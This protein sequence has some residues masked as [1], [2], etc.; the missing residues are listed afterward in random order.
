[1]TWTMLGTGRRDVANWPALVAALPTMT[2]AWADL[3]GF[4]LDDLPAAT[5]PA[6]HLW[7]WSPGTWLRVRID[8][9]NWWAALLI[10]EPSDADPDLWATTEDGLTVDHRK[11]IHWSPDM[12]EVAQRR[13]TPE[14]ALDRQMIELVPLR[15]STATF[16]GPHDSVTHV[17]TS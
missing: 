4:H 15:P 12:G 9:P 5:P 2:A 17:G 1:M 6:S 14:N 11:V 10:P 8:Q 13:V 7:A 16:L 3:T